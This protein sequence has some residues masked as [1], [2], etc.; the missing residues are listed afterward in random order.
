M[1]FPHLMN[2]RAVASNMNRM[3]PDQIRLHVI[4]AGRRFSGVW[5]GRL[6]IP[7]SGP[8]GLSSDRIGEKVLDKWSSGSDEE[9][10]AAVTAILAG[11]TAASTSDPDQLLQRTSA[12][13][14]RLRPGDNPSDGN[15]KLPGVNVVAQVLVQ[16]KLQVST[17]PKSTYFITPPTPRSRQQTYFYL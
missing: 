7:R 17:S 13:R 9:L 3:P 5:A 14:S 8:Q 4:V 15:E 6:S 12:P 11:D 10:K 1:I 2:V 16:F